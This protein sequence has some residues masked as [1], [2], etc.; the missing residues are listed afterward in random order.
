VL[1]CCHG[2]WAK[3]STPPPLVG[4][5]YIAFFD[6]DPSSKDVVPYYGGYCR[7]ISDKYWESHQPSRN[8]HR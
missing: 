2:R 3:I 6:I 7:V 4:L 8:L 5:K 1:L